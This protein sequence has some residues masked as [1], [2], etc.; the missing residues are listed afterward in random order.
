MDPSSRGNVVFA[1][2]KS[3]ERMKKDPL[4]EI[5]LLS[6]LKIWDLVAVKRKGV[7][8]QLLVMGLVVIRL[9]LIR[10]TV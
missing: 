2:R 3:A 5:G 9:L 7:L 10:V 4:N 1:L 8:V 6:K